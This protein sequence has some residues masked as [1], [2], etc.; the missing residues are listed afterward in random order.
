MP[1]TVLAQ[2]HVEERRHVRD[3]RRLLHVVRH[4]HDRVVPLQ[5]V[6]RSSIRPVAIG[7]SAEQ[8]S[9]M[10]RTSGSTASARAM[11]SRCCCPPESPRRARLEPV[12][13]LVP[14]R[15]LTKRA[16]HPLVQVLLHPEHA[17]PVGDVLVDRLDEGFGFWK[18]MPIR[19]RTWT[20]STP[21]RRGLDRGR[22][23]RPVTSAPGI[24]SFIR[25]K[26]RMYVL[27]PHPDGPMK[28]VT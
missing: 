13:H 6:I 14:E 5:L 27:F 25:L 10:R 24:R 22:G 26:Q 7:S 17:R 11:Q 8:G 12:L 28:A 16:L 23:P 18:T 19:R 15:C 2:L 20:G 1:A 3:A 9:S 4:D 21:L